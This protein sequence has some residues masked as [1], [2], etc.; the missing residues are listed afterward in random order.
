VA[1]YTFVHGSGDAGANGLWDGDRMVASARELI[2]FGYWPSCIGWSDDAAKQ[3]GKR[4][5]NLLP[6]FYAASEDVWKRTGRTLNLKQ[7][8]AR[9]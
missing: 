3:V 6:R 7:W 2:V 4:L 1:R 9:Q 5:D 8:A